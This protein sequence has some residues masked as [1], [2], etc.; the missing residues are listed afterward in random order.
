[1]EQAKLGAQQWKSAQESLLHL[2]KSNVASV[3][4]IVRLVIK[5]HEPN[6]NLLSVFCSFSNKY[7]GLCRGGMDTIEIL[8]GR[9]SSA[10]SSALEDTDTGSKNLLSSIDRKSSRSRSLWNWSE[11]K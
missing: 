2:E 5:I 4:E 10:V 6:S 8:R 9:F 3:D 1:M 11:S 7:T